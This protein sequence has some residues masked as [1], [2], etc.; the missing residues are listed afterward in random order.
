M[1][2]DTVTLETIA[3]MI[4]AAR[5][6]E[7][8]AALE[9]FPQTD[10][11]RNEVMFLRGYLREMQFD[12]EGAFAAYQVVLEQDSDHSEAAFRAARIADRAG[13]DAAALDL[14][15]Q[16]VEKKPA[17][18]NALINLAILCEDYG[19]LEEAEGYLRAV[20][21]EHPNHGRARHFLKSVASSHTMVY[22][23]H[24]Q[25]EWERRSAVL[26]MPISDFELSVRSRNCLRQM[27]IRTLG[28]LLR[29]TE[30]E[31]LVYKNFGETSLN[32]IKAMLSQKGLRLGQELQPVEQPA[33]AASSGLPDDQSV[34]AN[35]PVAELELSV[36][37]RKALQRL[38][39]STI[40]ELALR[41][42]AELML[43]KNFG[44]T[45]LN[46]IKRQLVRFGLSLRNPAG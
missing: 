7:A 42:E 23:E 34:H 17:H 30:T 6:D 4:K 36:R 44:Q 3:E 22:D 29:A 1:M 26:D 10:E 13:D 38:G 28:D 46:E 15:S 32:E 39:V 27:N 24:T 5:Y 18:V 45:S 33:H 43:I 31:L 21:N 8:D 41:S 37:S 11:D 20:L 40:G 25:R 12:F 19:D 2:T 9:G 16:C 14:Y 35:L